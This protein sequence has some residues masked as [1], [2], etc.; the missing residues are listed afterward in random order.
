MHPMDGLSIAVR[1]VE[2]RANER[3]SSQEGKEVAS[4]ATAFIH[5]GQSSGDADFRS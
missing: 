1:D 3:F 4:N 2:F 5:F